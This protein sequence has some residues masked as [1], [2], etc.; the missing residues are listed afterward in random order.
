MNTSQVRCPECGET[1]VA[2]MTCPHCGVE[3]DSHVD[4]VVEVGETYSFRSSGR[5]V[6]V[7]GDRVETTVEVQERWA[8]LVSRTV[9]TA[10]VVDCEVV[11]G[12]GETTMVADSPSR[13][14]FLVEAVEDEVPRGLEDLPGEGTLPLRRPVDDQRVDGQKLLLYRNDA[15]I[16]LA[17]LVALARRKLT[18]CQVGDVFA[19]LLEAISAFND[20]GILHLYLNP[21]LVRVRP[22]GTVEG[23]PQVGGSSSGAE[24]IGVLGGEDTTVETPHAESQ[25]EWEVSEYDETRPQEPL[26]RRMSD[27]DTPDLSSFAEERTKLDEDTSEVTDNRVTGEHWIRQIGIEPDAEEP[28]RGGDEKSDGRVADSR[29][30]REERPAS[31]VGLELEVLVD[32]VSGL[33]SRDELPG[34]LEAIDG[35]SPP[36]MYGSVGP[37]P[38]VTSDVFS[39][40]MILYYLISG[41]RPPVSVYTRHRPAVPARNFRPEFPPGL[42]PV[43]K[44]S[45]RSDPE[46]R[47]PDISSMRAAFDDAL[48]AM[49]DRRPEWREESPAAEVAVDRHVG[50][51]KRDRNPVNQD[52]VFE[53]TSDDGEFGMIVVADGVS[54]A[55]FG[56]GAVASE[57]LIEVGQE[58]WNDILPTYLMDESFEPI[59]IIEGILEKANA[60]IV[61][62]VNERFTPFS[63]S[64][65]EVMG[66]TALVAIYRNGTVTL[67]SVGDSRAYLQR[68]P[69]LEQLTVDH[70][71]WTL[72]ILEGLA[73]DDALS[74]PRGDA[75][76]RCLGTFVVEDDHLDPVS[77][78]Y[79]IFQFSITEGDTLLLTTD[80]LVDFAGG[81]MISAE[82]NIQATLLAEPD[83]A[84]ACL[85]LILLANRGGGGDNIG[86]GVAQFE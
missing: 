72:S 15:G 60:R 31:G 43:V 44:R 14:G 82:E 10:R 18:I 24:E 23:I 70:N 55:S 35:F 63:G 66:T 84:L 51:A 20:A 3:V 42:G 16:S 85:E 7:D 61:E 29:S 54:T 47:Y 21:E 77:P 86:L 33:F 80:G 6:G 9:Y 49:E 4:S 67:G 12:K 71:L 8:D 64:P 65:H 13:T 26:G 50:I 27:L 48:E 17:E 69:G 25:T 83:P 38:D 34:D 57:L 59:E 1:V 79:D 11:D 19:A 75:L 81:N 39:A 45:T 58:V 32:A 5:D 76:A 37:D 78:G 30:D 28:A 41:R 56:T 52:D 36:E 40:G 74:M 73:A 53:G 68:G 22:R 46:M 2:G 62:Y